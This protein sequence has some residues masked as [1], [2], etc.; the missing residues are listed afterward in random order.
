MICVRGILVYPALVRLQSPRVIFSSKYDKY[1]SSCLF[2]LQLMCARSAVRDLQHERSGRVADKARG[3]AEC[4]ITHQSRTQTPPSREGKGLVNIE[5]FLGFAAVW[6]H[7][8][9][10]GAQSRHMIPTCTTR[11]LATGTS[12]SGLELWR[13]GRQSIELDRSQHLATGNRVWLLSYPVV[14]AATKACMTPPSRSS[15]S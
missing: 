11:L 10:G 13:Y 9:Y 2:K 15:F 1:L 7:V 8:T 3:K 6:S 5:R 4:F 12:R 14:F